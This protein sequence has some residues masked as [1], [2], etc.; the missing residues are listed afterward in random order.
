[1][2]VLLPLQVAG[3][4][5]RSD[6]RTDCNSWTYTVHYPNSSIGAIDNITTAWRLEQDAAGTLM[7]TAIINGRTGY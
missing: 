5:L 7:F 1:M 2:L 3:A 6:P 4:T